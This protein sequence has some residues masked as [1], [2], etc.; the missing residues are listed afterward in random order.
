MK[1]KMPTLPKKGILAM[2][3]VRV[4]IVIVLVAVIIIALVRAGLLPGQ[5]SLALSGKIGGNV[6][7]IVG[8]LSFPMGGEVSGSTHA[9]YAME[10]GFEEEKPKV[11]EVT[12]Y[13]THHC[14]HCVRFKPAFDEFKAEATKSGLKVSD[15][16]APEEMSKKGIQGVPTVLLKMSDGSEVEYKGDR[17]KDGLMAEV[18][19][20]M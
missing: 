16:T 6:A 15:T 19:R 18:K 13:H 17:S 1:M 14:P 11:V 12:L 10:E 7:P 3:V 8:G 9:G 4:L 2:P 5:F 20:Y